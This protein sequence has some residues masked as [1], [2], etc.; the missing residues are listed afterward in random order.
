MAGG[1]LTP[2]R[3]PNGHTLSAGLWALRAL[4]RPLDRLF[5]KLGMGEQLRIYARRR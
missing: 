2:I 4:N 5:I 1:S 3:A